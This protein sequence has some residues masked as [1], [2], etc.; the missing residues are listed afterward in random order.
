MMKS[1]KDAS[2]LCWT[3]LSQRG[4]RNVGISGSNLV[5]EDSG[6]SAFLPFYDVR[7]LSHEVVL[8][9]KTLHLASPDKNVYRIR[10]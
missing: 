7:C 3:D 2:L 4:D 8:S 6:A 5:R 9:C 1:N 10:K